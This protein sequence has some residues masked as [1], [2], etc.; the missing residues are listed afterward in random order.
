MRRCCL[1]MLS[2]VLGLSACSGGTET[3]TQTTTPPS[4][5][6]GATST[7]VK[8]VGPSTVKAALLTEAD[9]PGDGWKTD[10]SLFEK[11]G[12]TTT[13]DPAAPT[14]L[15]P[16]FCTGQAP[17]AGLDLTP[18]AESAVLLINADGTGVAEIIITV[19]GDAAKT[20]QA[21]KASVESCFGKQR[22]TQLMDAVGISVKTDLPS[23]GD[24]SIAFRDEVVP[25]GSSRALVSHNVIAVR[26]PVLVALVITS[27]TAGAPMADADIAKVVEAADKKLANL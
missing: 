20:F 17:P 3:Q 21:L 24:E 10:T 22:E 13:K 1:A 15:A 27:T 26:G 23:V 25:P 14:T 4:T 7:A 19:E 5:E 9:L 18:D 6:A 16:G 8:A 11:T 12:P 2:L